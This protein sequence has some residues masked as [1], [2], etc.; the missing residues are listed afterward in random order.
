M[1]AAKPQ[2]RRYSKDS[3][4]QLADQNR[5]GGPLPT[6][7]DKPPDFHPPGPGF[8]GLT[9]YSAVFTEGETHMSVECEP[10]SQVKNDSGTQPSDLFALKS[11]K[12]QEGAQI[13]AVMRD[14]PKYQQAIVRRY[15]VQ[16]LAPVIP[17]VRECID[18]VATDNLGGNTCDDSR[19]LNLSQRIFLR[20]AMPFDPKSI[21]GLSQSPAYLMGDNLCWEVVGL[22]LTV[23]GLGA[24]S[25][26][27]VSLGG[28]DT[29]LD[30]KEIAKQLLHAGDKCILLC[31]EFGH[32]NDLGVWLILMNHILHTQVYGDAGKWF[33]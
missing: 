9:S 26:D 13:L 24:I 27:E 15:E 22:M 5:N 30:W 28:Y 31:H 7:S 25:L 16:S 4:P 21:S 1:T 2:T 23:A 32:L 20:T 12:V 17:F 11:R 8:L 14:L 10:E 29:T 33:P 19:L 6:S 18:M 3:S